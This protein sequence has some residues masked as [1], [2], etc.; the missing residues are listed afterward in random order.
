[1]FFAFDCKLHY[2][3]KGGVTTQQLRIGL[4]LSAKYF[5]T[6]KADHARSDVINPILDPVDDT[7]PG[8]VTVNDTLPGIVTVDDNLPGIV[9]VPVL[10]DV[11]N[12]SGGNLLSRRIW[13][14]AKDTAIVRNRQIA[15]DIKRIV[16]AQ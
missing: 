1:M 12:L 16:T 3:N 10:E 2:L 6:S 8:I 14:S 5:L 11:T 15:L 7:L 13:T 9:N 4:D